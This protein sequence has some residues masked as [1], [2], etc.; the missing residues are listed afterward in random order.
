M[1]ENEIRK[2]SNDKWRLT[3]CDICICSTGFFLPE[4]KLETCAVCKKAYAFGG[5]RK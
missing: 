4:F 1:K 2:T 5:D 3:G